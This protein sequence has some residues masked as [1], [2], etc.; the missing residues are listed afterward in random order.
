MISTI[1]NTKMGSKTTL[2]ASIPESLGFALGEIFGKSKSKEAFESQCSIEKIVQ[3]FKCSRRL[4]DFTCD[5]KESFY[6]H[7]LT[8]NE[9]DEQDICVYCERMFVIEN[10]AAHMEAQHGNRRFQCTKYVSLQVTLSKYFEDYLV[11]GLACPRMPGAYMPDMKAR[12]RTLLYRC[13]LCTFR[14]FARGDFEQHLSCTHPEVTMPHR[15]AENGLTTRREDYKSGASLLHC[16]YCRITAEHHGQISVPPSDLPAYSGHELVAHFDEEHGLGNRLTCLYCGEP[17]KDEEDALSHMT[18]LHSDWP[19]NVLDREAKVP[20]RNTTPAGQMATPPPE[21][22]STPKRY[23]AAPRSV[24]EKRQRK[25]CNGPTMETTSPRSDT[26]SRPSANI[27]SFTASS[28]KSTSKPRGILKKKASS[29]TSE[30]RE[31]SQVSLRCAACPCVG[32]EA[33]V[34]L[35][36]EALALHMRDKHNVYYICQRCFHGEEKFRLIQA[37]IAQCESATELDIVTLKNGVLKT[38][39]KVRSTYK[40]RQQHAANAG[41]HRI[42]QSENR[43]GSDSLYGGVASRD[44]YVPLN[45]SS[46]VGL[47]PTEN[48]NKCIKG[49]TNDSEA[50]RN[51]AGG[52]NDKRYV[53]YY[54]QPVEPIGSNVVVNY[55]G[56]RIPFSRFDQL[57]RGRRV[58]VKKCSQEEL[59]RWGAA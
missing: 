29:V 43:G 12:A 9:D 38:S 24:Q 41:N 20:S 1:P 57:H 50:T 48:N 55:E 22:N 30:L 26:V 32:Q 37:H 7:I 49:K 21:Q 13:S 35:S 5:D 17:L 18:E 34:Y 39:S 6:C 46:K 52:I 33:N 58:Q 42:S 2:T 51:G 11:T 14:S 36:Q 44:F 53:S 27:A 25:L 23:S 19:I 10:L 54:G 3:F 40:E 59:S 15:P 31:P 16:V 4:C 8:H 56:E 47:T 45:D 28:E